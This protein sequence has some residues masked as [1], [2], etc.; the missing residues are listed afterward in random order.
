MDL[1]TEITLDEI[2]YDVER[3]EF[4]DGVRGLVTKAMEFHRDDMCDSEFCYL[5]WAEDDGLVGPR[6][7]SN[8]KELMRDDPRCWQF[9]VDSGPV[10]GMHFVRA[11]I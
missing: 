6:I 7:R 11:W 8:V 9:T 4:L 2:L 5:V 1:V 3:F 10:G